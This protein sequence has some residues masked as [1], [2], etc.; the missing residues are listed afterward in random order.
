MEL[1][2]EFLHEASIRLPKGVGQTVG[3]VGGLILGD[4]AV[5]AGVVNPAMVIVIALTAISSF[6]VPSY[7]LSL[8][9]R[10]VRAPLMV[11]STI[12]GIYGLVMGMI[13]IFIHLAALTSLGES[14]LDPWG[15]YESDTFKNTFF[16]AP[17]SA[18]KRRPRGLRTEDLYVKRHLMM[19]RVGGRM[20]H[21][22]NNFLS[23]LCFNIG[24]C[25]RHIQSSNACTSR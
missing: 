16:R 11:V 17:L 5:R 9:S 12:Y 25:Y 3:V 19:K 18:F 13:V 22:K 7:T 14:Y 6:I 2:V 10:I 21:E 4:A 20:K 1:G 15:Q 24:R 23:A 8:A